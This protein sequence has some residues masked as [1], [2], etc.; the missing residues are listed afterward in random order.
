MFKK[1]KLNVIMLRST[2]KC[3]ADCL[4]CGIPENVQ[5][6]MTH[7]K[8]ETI[9]SKLAP[10]LS[11]DF[12]V[13]FSG[14]EAL[15]LSPEYYYKSKE[16]IE[17]YAPKEFELSVQTNFLIYNEKT[18]KM[19]VEVFDNHVSTSYDFFSK[20]RNIK[21]DV[22]IYKK[23]FFENI[24]KWRERNNKNLVIINMFNEENKDKYDEIF[25]IA[26]KNRYLLKIN[27]IHE[28]GKAL[29]NKDLLVKEGYYNEYNNTMIKMTKRIL[30]EKPN[31]ILMNTFLLLKQYLFPGNNICPNSKNCAGSFIS[32][33]PDGEI[34][35]C[36]EMKDFDILKFGNLLEQSA[37]EIF[38]K[39]NKNI[40]AVS[41]RSVLIP[42]DCKVCPY[43]NSCH[44]G[45]MA[46]RYSS[47]GNI[48]GKDPL[49]KYYKTTFEMF[50]KYDKKE[51]KEFY[52]NQLDLFKYKKDN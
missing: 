9:F 33:E 51:L 28:T 4:H 26:N 45:C 1:K 18:Q 43:L 32:I 40:L 8:L 2:Y 16:I 49:C 39:A 42:E 10:Y 6:K 31:F 19:F 52:L 15:L 21:G 35:N 48:Y 30:N 27:H 17:K 22:E 47:S 23:I 34:Y 41:K 3:N 37:D 12:Q 25:D 14:G 29:T 46:S 7:E 13:I 5:I 20:L 44:S 11:D 24:N 38:E 50:D 36:N